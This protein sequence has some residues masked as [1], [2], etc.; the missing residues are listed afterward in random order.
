MAAG[1]K[2]EENYV[3]FDIIDGE[4]QNLAHPKDMKKYLKECFS[5]F[6][7][8]KVLTE[9][10]LD[11]YPV[12]SLVNTMKLAEYVL[13]LFFSLSSSFGNSYDQISL[14]FNGG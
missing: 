4:K 11:S 9:K 14:K 5:K 1:D 6:T 12:P 2:G 13:E 3:R 7:S 10:I 8:D